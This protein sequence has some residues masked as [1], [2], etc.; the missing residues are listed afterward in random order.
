MHGKCWSE[1][2]KGKRLFGRPVLRGENNVI[3]YF[4]ENGERV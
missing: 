2:L 1:N 3:I 4:K